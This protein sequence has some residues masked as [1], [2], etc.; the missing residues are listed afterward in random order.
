MAPKAP[1]VICPHCCSTDV[2]APEQP[3]DADI[4]VCRHCGHQVSYGDMREQVRR[5]FEGALGMIRE[6]VASKVPHLFE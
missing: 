1:F 3:T 5:A 2:E 6:Q 4:V